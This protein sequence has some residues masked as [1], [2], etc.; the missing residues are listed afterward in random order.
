MALPR[1]IPE[2]QNAKRIGRSLNGKVILSVPQDVSAEWQTRF[3]RN[4]RTVHRSY[5]LHC[6]DYEII[7]TYGLE[8]QG[9]VNYYTM[10]H[11]VAKRLYS[12]KYHFQ[13]SLVKTLAAKHK[14]SATWVYR[15]YSR[16][17]EHGITG[18]ITEISNPKNP[19]KQITARFGDKP[20]RYNPKAF[21]RD[22]IA[23]MYHGGSELI[24]R[25]LANECE[26]CGSSEGVNVHH[27]RKLKDIKKKYQGRS[28]P[29]AWAKFMMARNRKTVIVCHQCHVRIHNGR[30]D[31]RKVE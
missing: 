3:V 6:S 22:R 30:Y 28:E 17:S 12:V 11:N 25:F 15:R 7:Q 16:K 31:Q 5:L 8:F 9:L 19:A 14:R 21:I 24:R 13:Q 2:S 26:L 29:P 23:R 18:L 1:E 4:G 10:A 20:I 27:I